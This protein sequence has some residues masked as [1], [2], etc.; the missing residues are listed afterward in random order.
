MD[1]QIEHV[2]M[3]QLH[4]F[5]IQ[6]VKHIYLTANVLQRLKVVVL[7]IQYVKQL[8]FKELVLLMQK[9]KF[10]FGI[11]VVQDH[12][13]IKL[14]SMPQTLIQMMLLVHNI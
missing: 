1:V 11:Q 5:R 4:W 12:A 2:K 13:K 9:E 10:V 8:Q 14:V 7:Q 3:L 6:I